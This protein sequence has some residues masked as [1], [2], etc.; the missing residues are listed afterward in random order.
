MMMKICGH[1]NQVEKNIERGPVS[2]ILLFGQS[3]FSI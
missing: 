3:Q 1:V 2:G